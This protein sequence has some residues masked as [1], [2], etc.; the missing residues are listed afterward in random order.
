MDPL[1]PASSR[2]VEKPSPTALWGS[3]PAFTQ[4]TLSP[5]STVMVAGEKL[6]SRIWTEPE[7][8]A[9]ARGLAAGSAGAGVGG[10]GGA[11]VGVGA[12]GGGGGAGDGGGSGAGWGAGTVSVV[13]VLSVVVSAGSWV[14]SA[15]SVTGA[16]STTPQ[17]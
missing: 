6:K 2:E 10:G 17:A 12:G 8:A 5:T 16:A 3:S 9:T 14:S 7:A 13:S 1:S 11:G 4:V 15:W